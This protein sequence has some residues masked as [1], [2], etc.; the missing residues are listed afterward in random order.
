M[1]E[2]VDAHESDIKNIEVQMGQILMS[3]NN[4]P[5]GT[6]P[7]DTQI[8]PKDQGPKQL[9]VVSLHVI[10]QPSQEETNTQIEV[11]KE[12][13]TAQEP[14][15]E[16]NIALKEMPGYAK[17][18]KDLMSQ[19]FDFQDLSTVTLT[20]TCNAVV[21][22][23]VAEKLYHLE[24]FHNSLHHCNFAFAK[25]L[26]DLGPSINFM[27]LAIYKRLGIGKARPTS[28]LLQLT[29]KTVKRPSGILD[30]MLIQV[31]KFVFPADFV[32]LDCKV[33]EEIPIILGRSFLAI[34]RAIIDCETGELKMRLNDEEITF[35][36]QKSMRRLSEFANCS[37][38]DVV[39]VIVE[40]DDE[41]LT[42]EDLL[43]A[44][45]VNL[46]EVNGEELVEWVLALEGRGFWDG[47]LE[48]EPLHL[49]NRETPPAKPSIEEPPKLELKPL[50]AHLRYEFLGP[51]SILPGIISSSL[52]DVQAQQLL[53]VLKECKTAIG[54]TMTDIKGI[55][56]AYCMHKILLEEGHKPS[57]EHQRR[58]NPN[59]KEVAKK[60]GVKWLDAGI[61]FPISDS[62]WVRP[63]Q[64]A[65]KKGAMTVV[66]N[67]NNELIFT[68]IITGWRICMDYRKL[69]LAT[70]K[71]HF[72]LPFIDHMLDRLAERSHFCFL[73]GYLGYN[74]ISIALED[75]ERTSFTCPYGIYAFRRMPFGLC[76]APAT[77]QRCMMAIFTDM[78]EDKMEM[79]MDDFSV[80]GNSFDE[81][82]INLTR[83]LKRC[84]ETNLWGQ[85]KYK[86]MHPIY[87]ASRTLSGSQL[88]YTVT[89]KEMLVMVFAFDKFRSY[90]NGSKVIVYTDHAA[91]RFLIE[92]KEPKPRL[93]RW[94]LLLQEFDLEIRDRKVTENQVV[95]HLSRLEGAEISIEVEDILEN[96]PDEQLLTRSLE[97]ACHASAYDGHFGG[98]R[99]TTK[100]LVAGFYWPTVFRDAHKWV[101]GYYLPKWVEAVALPTNDARV[102]VGFLKKNIFTHFG[103]PRAI[104]SDR[105][106]HFYNRAF[107][108]LLA[109]YDVRHKVATP[110][111]PQ[112]SG[113][114]EVLNREIKSV[115]TKTVNAT[116][117][118]WAKKLDNALW[119]Y[120]TAFKHQLVCHHIS[121][122]V[123][124][125]K[126]RTTGASSSNQAGSSRARGSAPARPFD[127]IRFVSA[128]AQDRFMDKAPKKP[129]LERGIDIGSVQLGCPSLYNELVRRGLQI[130]LEEPDEGNVMV[131]REFYANVKECV[132]GIVTVRRKAVDA[133]VEAIRRI[134]Q[135]PAP[136]DPYEDYYEMYG[137]SLT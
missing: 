58:L 94:V 118:D 95:D 86:L 53:Q 87:Y 29:D 25:A 131:V 41:T 18:M 97:E 127:S 77:F 75:R 92:K 26:C 2:R 38:I 55:S 83:V 123:P 11:E 31:G 1:S 4:H 120:K 74:Q 21:T 84:I 24:E 109:K 9:M 112:T 80:V 61:I 137:R 59:M 52:L 90:L 6:L 76:N 126:R 128:K 89:E 113:Q 43:V 30:D 111:H 68:R 5:H 57:R 15:V 135:L 106:I 67:D 48:F 129:I 78:V 27:P 110:Y 105:G 70:R 119:A 130:L 117:T 35:N 116:R 133:S 10:V 51:N 81:C 33:D 122:M 96:F 85:R 16:V 132:N 56:P 82:L 54:W 121:T 49:E 45:L 93:I 22:R 101:K 40:A 66:K 63:V 98:V 65:P 69:Y 39:D 50:P 14:V 99:T 23:L 17:M 20:Q 114:V 28:M 36:V 62:N 47:T 115:L 64:C 136:V 100:V 88:N 44:C 103:T 79:F 107:E 125:R 37:F 73:D 19:K 8:N 134:Y 108:K 91:L 13:E 104:I 3:L 72:P 102:V 42:I 46:D 124:S 7:T 32:I 71:D 34:G 12:A 60:E